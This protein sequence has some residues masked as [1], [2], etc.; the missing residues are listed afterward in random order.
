MRLK[1]LLFWSR[2]VCDEL[3]I[4]TQSQETYKPVLK[5]AFLAPLAA[6]GFAALGLGGCAQQQQVARSSEYFPQSIYGEASPRVVA[7]GQEI[8]HGGGKYLVGH[9]YI[10]AGRMYYPSERTHYTEVGYGLDGIIPQVLPFF[11][12]EV[13][14]QWQDATYKGLGFRIGTTLKFGR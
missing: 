12:V 3:R 5:P 1:S 14:S 13:I 7:D 8:P 9:P 10:V 6:A 2:F 4:G 11:R